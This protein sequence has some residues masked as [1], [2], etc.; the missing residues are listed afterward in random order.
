MAR[1]PFHRQARFST[2]GNQPDGFEINAVRPMLVLL[3]GPPCAG[4]THLYAF[5]QDECVLPAMSR[6]VLKEAPFAALC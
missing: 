3:N 5:I 4:K 6:D 1:R 2:D